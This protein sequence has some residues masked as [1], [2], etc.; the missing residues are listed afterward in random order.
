MAA[1]EFAWERS[2]FEMIKKACTVTECLKIPVGN[3][4]YCE[5]HRRRYRVYGT[6]TPLKVCCE[7]RCEFVWI[8][9]AYRGTAIMCRTCINYFNEYI[10][11]LPRWRGGIRAHGVS[12]TQYINLLV[13][14]GFSCALCLKTPDSYNRM[15][16]D[17][18]HS[19]C[20]G[21]YSC[22]KCVRGLVCLGCNALLGHLETKQHL[23]AEYEKTYKYARPL[24]EPK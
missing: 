18:D 6:A 9:K 17:H 3:H 21:A 20:P 16:I 5:M 24:K 2:R 19:C 23:I 15:S 4:V 7:C 13:E 8:D 10:E 12:I 11:Y 1:V 22:G 14:Q